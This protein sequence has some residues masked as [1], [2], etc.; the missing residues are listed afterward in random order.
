MARTRLTAAS[1]ATNQRA[2][3]IDAVEV[4]SIGLATRAHS[5]ESGVLLH[6]LIDEISLI[7]QEITEAERL[8]VAR[9]GAA[10]A[11]GKL[12]LDELGGIGDR[13]PAT[14][15]GDHFD[16]R[17]RLPRRVALEHHL[18]DDLGRRK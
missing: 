8:H 13:N 15:G 1:T 6:I 12:S 11:G 18:V 7:H 2:V 17:A 4:R 10:D 5:P 3:L 14:V 16:L 9:S